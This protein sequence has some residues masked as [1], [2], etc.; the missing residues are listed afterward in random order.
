[1]KHH[2]RKLK[3]IACVLS[4]FSR[5]GQLLDER[6][7]LIVVASVIVQF[8]LSHKLN[9][10]A[11]VLNFAWS[12]RYES[13]LNFARRVKYLNQVN[14]VQEKYS[15]C[16]SVERDIDLPSHTL[17]IIV[18]VEPLLPTILILHLGHLCGKFIV[19][20]TITN[21]TFSHKSSTMEPSEI[22]CFD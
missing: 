10:D 22:F 4:E 20:V 16:F 15:T 1:M 14:C 8:N 9:L 2:L 17:A 6:E 13:G 12:F 19:K 3:V 7:E 11:V 18:K 5:P 21:N